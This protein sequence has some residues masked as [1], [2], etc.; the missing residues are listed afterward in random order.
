MSQASSVLVECAF[1]IAN[2]VIRHDAAGHAHDANRAHGRL[3]AL[4]DADP[5]DDLV[6]G[7]ARKL[8]RT[9][10][11]A[12]MIDADVIELACR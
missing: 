3:T 4:I 6:L 11:L 9:R 5:G 8:G 1:H 2:T 7:L 10:A 12:V